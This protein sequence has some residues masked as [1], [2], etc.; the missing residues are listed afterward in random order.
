MSKFRNTYF[1]QIYTKNLTFF[2]KNLLTKININKEVI[3]ILTS[4]ICIDEFKK[5]FTTIYYDNINNYEFYA[6][7][8]I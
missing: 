3:D 2:I 5:A 8:I 4:K 6:Y 1:D 7:L